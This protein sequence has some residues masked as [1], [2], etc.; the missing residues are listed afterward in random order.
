MRRTWTTTGVFVC[1]RLA[2]QAAD[3]QGDKDNLAAPGKA[4]KRE[5]RRF[6]GRTFEQWQAD[7]LTDLSVNRRVKALDALRAFAANGYAAEAATA[8]LEVMGA[9]DVEKTSDEE[10]IK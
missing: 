2:A 7:L 1:R 9:Y 6:D 5:Q 3:A 4:I 10:E 8:V